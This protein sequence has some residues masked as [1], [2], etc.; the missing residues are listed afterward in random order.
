MI[1]LR[2]AAP[3]ANEYGN[4]QNVSEMQIDWNLGGKREHAMIKKKFKVNERQRIFS[5]YD[6]TFLIPEAKPELDDDED[7]NVCFSFSFSFSLC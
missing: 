4:G 2:A 3:T 6:K 7:E 5:L 1:I